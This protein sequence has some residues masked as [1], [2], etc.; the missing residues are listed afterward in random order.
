ML[1]EALKAAA[2][3]AEELEK[4]QKDQETRLAICEDRIHA[5]ENES[6]RLKGVLSKAKN[7]LYDVILS[8]EELE[9]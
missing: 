5:L 4:R 7:S 9:R 6:R 3:E 8:L 2:Q 1:S